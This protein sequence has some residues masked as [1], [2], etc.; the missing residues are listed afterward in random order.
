M[1]KNFSKV[2]ALAIMSLLIA[3]IFTGCA[4]NESKSAMNAIHK[5]GKIVVGTASGHYP[6]EMTD[7]QGNL[8]GYDIDVAKA[9]GK[10]MGVEV[11]FQNYA[12][13]GLIPALQSNKVDIVIAGMTATDKR[14]EV[15]DFT[16]PYFVYG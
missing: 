10:E 15:V 1:F 13:S 8:V 7:K 5:K 16:E 3:L 6:F 2:I 14:R 11:E 12:F 9:I 4:S